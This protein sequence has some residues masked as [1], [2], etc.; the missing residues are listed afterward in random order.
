MGATRQPASSATAAAVNRGAAAAGNGNAAP[1]SANAAAARGA[2]NASGLFTAALELSSEFAGWCCSQMLLL[3][4][5]DDL[6]MV[7]LLI[8][9]DSNSEVAEYAQMV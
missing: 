8:S 9:T 6:T 2:A 4:G 1:S 3:Q 7:E 5:N